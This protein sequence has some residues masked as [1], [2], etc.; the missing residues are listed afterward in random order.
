M[1]TVYVDLETDSLREDCQVIQLAAVAVDQDYAELA[2]FERKLFFDI[3]KA[4]PEAL[5]I[6]GYSDDVWKRE[7][8]NPAQ[9]CK[10]FAL[11]IE[12]YRQIEIISKAGK[13]YNVARLVAHNAPF[14]QPRLFR[15]FK[16]TGV[17][18][19]ADIRVR[20][21]LQLAL[22]ELDKRQAEKYLPA[23]YRLET[24]CRYFGIPWEDAHSA[25]SDCRMAVQLAKA[26]Q[27]K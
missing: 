12:P 17:F 27:E 22:W 16:E 14:D 25:L 1:K 5:L 21:T 3:E 24:L 13:P 23:N 2:A 18:L 20:C 15:L 8:V 10:E 4:E 7:A 9:A 19:A 26:L 6:N 11:F